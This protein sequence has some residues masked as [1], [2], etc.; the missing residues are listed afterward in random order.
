MSQ[1]SITFLHSSC[2]RINVFE[3]FLFTNRQKEVF[4]NSV[5]RNTRAQSYPRWLTFDRSVLE[6]TILSVSCQ[7]SDFCPSIALFGNPTSAFDIALPPLLVAAHE[8][9]SLDW[10]SLSNS[11]FAVA[12]SIIR[13]FGRFARESYVAMPGACDASQCAPGGLGT[14]AMSAQHSIRKAMASGRVDLGHRRARKQCQRRH[15]L[16][17]LG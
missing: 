11:A 14:V 15:R 9:T 13:R 7:A 2:W 16:L 3:S 12:L 8:I 6:R 17:A 10:P 1:S 4:I 5:R